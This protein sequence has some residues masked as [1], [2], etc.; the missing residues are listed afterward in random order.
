MQGTNTLE[1]ILLQMP[2][3]TDVL[4]QYD[5]KKNSN[6]MNAFYVCSVLKNAVSTDLIGQ[7]FACKQ[8]GDVLYKDKLVANINKVEEVTTDLWPVFLG[9]SILLVLV[10]L[11]Y[12]YKKM[13]ALGLI[14]VIVC[15]LG[16]VGIIE[17]FNTAKFKAHKFAAAMSTSS[18]KG[19][20][21]KYSDTGYFTI[22]KSGHVVEVTDPQNYNVI[23]EYVMAITYNGVPVMYARVP[24]KAGDPV[25][26]ETNNYPSLP[27]VEIDANDPFFTT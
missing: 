14:F 17:T 23:D 18:K 7:N 15:S 6:E 8:N 1:E 4:V 25:I 5:P 11:Y 10:S 22:N 21:Y 20:A 26:S 27:S 19:N 12:K 3:S 2:M 24:P 9:V 16:L 13:A